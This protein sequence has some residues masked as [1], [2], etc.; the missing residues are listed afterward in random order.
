MKANQLKFCTWQIQSD[1]AKPVSEKCQTQNQN[2]HFELWKTVIMESI[3]LHAGPATLF[4]KKAMLLPDTAK[5]SRT[6]SP[7]GYTTPL[8]YSPCPSKSFRERGRRLVVRRKQ[9]P[10]L[11]FKTLSISSTPSPDPTK[12]KFFPKRRIS[13]LS[14]HSHYKAKEVDFVG[15]KLIYGKLY[16][17]RP[18]EIKREPVGQARTKPISLPLQDC[19]SKDGI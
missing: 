11:P 17:L 12:A 4:D 13:R 6:G 8:V 1:T 15:V 3:S 18:S 19:V 5:P 16:P 7:Q 9:R 2:C 10:F 14:F